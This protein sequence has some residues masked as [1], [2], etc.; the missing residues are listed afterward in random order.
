MWSVGKFEGRELVYQFVSRNLNRTT[1]LIP[2]MISQEIIR[3]EGGG[4]SENPFL[5]QISLSSFSFSDSC[6][7]HT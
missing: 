3:A 6:D 4:F 1:W 2:F 5:S 7:S